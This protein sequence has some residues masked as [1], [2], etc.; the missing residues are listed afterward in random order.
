MLEQAS[1]YPFL[2]A[3]QQEEVEPFRLPDLQATDQPKGQEVRSVQPGGQVLQSGNP[4]RSS[5]RDALQVF[6]NEEASQETKDG[7]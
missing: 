4:M 2:C 3:R 5:Y 6:K 7:L 1:A